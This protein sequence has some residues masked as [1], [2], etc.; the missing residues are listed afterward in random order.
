MTRTKTRLPSPTAA[1]EEGLETVALELAA[2]LVSAC[3]APALLIERGGRLRQA[4][5]AAR[6]LLRLNSSRETGREGT[7]NGAGTPVR[8]LL[9]VG[10][11]E[12]LVISRTGET[13]LVVELPPNADGR[14]RGTRVRVEPVP[15][16]QSPLSQKPPNQ[17]SLS[18]RSLGQGQARAIVAFLETP[19]RRAAEGSRGGAGA[20]GFD[21]IFGNDPALLA[22]K[23]A[24]ARFAQ[25]L[26]PV[27]LLAETGT[28]KELL[29]RALHE[30]SP[31]NDQP[32][33]AI[34]CGALSP[35]LLE[36][37]LFGYA[38]GAFTGASREGHDGK[39][40]A[41]RGGT[42]FLDEVAEMPGP[43]QAL[44][45]RVLEDGTYYRVGENRPRQ[46]DVRLICATCRDLPRLVADGGF[47]QDL[48]YRINGAC[49]SLPPVRQRVD[50]AEL[51]LH[52][53]DQLA[54]RPDLVGNT[55]H[56]SGP[57]RLS[58]EA[59]EWMVEHPWPGNVRQLKTALQHALI[60]CDGGEIGL[61]H[62]PARLETLITS[63]DEPSPPPARTLPASPEPLDTPTP[64]SPSTAAPG[65]P[66]PASSRSP[67]PPQQAPVKTLAQRE[68]D[69]LVRAVDTA[70]GNLSRAARELGI[71]RS[72][73]YRRLRK[74]G[75]LD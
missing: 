43:L 10:W 52:L 47:R 69:R 41:A 18:Q 42:L 73:L 7:G 30:S 39:I 31:R 1:G 17:S 45:L 28:G 67:T 63:N 36:S 8:E 21:A 44:L 40:G 61:E 68:A 12:L 37:E 25:T 6:D 71:A 9:G 70:G 13:D 72:T 55:G 14:R 66:A 62:L 33:V 15:P 57:P 46:A 51:V 26:L 29:A 75:L 22:A 34:N 56:R 38:P 50:V 60:L 11:R 54:D 3:P 2:R 5:S 24:A 48:F 20:R 49:L 74:H 23:S 59:L 27:L 64:S 35:H 4:N 19:A 65:S 16:S 53:L 32:F 58:P